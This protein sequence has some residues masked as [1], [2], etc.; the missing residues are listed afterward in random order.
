MLQPEVSL[1]DNIMESLALVHLGENKFPQSRKEAEKAFQ[2]CIDPSNFMR[3]KLAFCAFSATQ[4]SHKRLG[5]TKKIMTL[6]TNVS[7]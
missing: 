4:D 7:L 6:V 3:N 1:S 2:A 5:R